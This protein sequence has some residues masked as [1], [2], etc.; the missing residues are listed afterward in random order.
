MC[1]LFG[2]TAGTQPVSARFWLLEA[3]GSLEEQS[4]RNRDGSGIGYFA[5]DGTPVL[6][7][8]PEAAFEDVEFISTARKA[9]STTFVSHVRYATAGTLRE[10]N[11]HPFAMAGRLMAHN[12]GFGELDVLEAELGDAG[13]AVTGDTDSERYFALITRETSRHDGDVGAGIAAAAKWIAQTLPLF[14]LNV[15]VAQSDQLWALRYPDLYELHV[16]ARQAGGHQGGRTLHATSAEVHIH[17]PE[18]E[19]HPAVVVSSERMDEHPQ[20]DSIAAGELVHVAP[21]LTVTRKIVLPNPPA[22]FVPP[23]LSVHPG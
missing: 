19:H 17:S 8:Q 2:M 23:D 9:T 14:S 21:D 1:R 20:W 5:A 11:T 6:D 13:T 18:L 16:L 4:R 12:G 10:E 3:P 7:K 22:R 15:I